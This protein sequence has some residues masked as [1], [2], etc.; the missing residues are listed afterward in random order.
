MGDDD[1]VITSA[2]L[3]LEI[4]LDRGKRTVK[5]WRAVAAPVPTDAGEL[6]TARAGELRA[7]LVLVVG[8][9]VDAQSAGR[10]DGRPAGRGVSRAER[11]IRRIE[12]NR[13]HGLTGESQGPRAV[14]AG[15][16]S[17]ARA[18]MPEHGPHGH[19]TWRVES[20]DGHPCSVRVGAELPQHRVPASGK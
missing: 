7:Q 3:E 9:D 19:R 4:R 15:D 10:A 1:G 8:K 11:H 14:V 17:D 5:Y 18:E 6:V 12:R 16:D 20:L 2:V 13:R